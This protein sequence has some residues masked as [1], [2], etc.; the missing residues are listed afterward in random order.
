MTGSEIRTPVL[1]KI[2]FQGCNSG[3]D[4]VLVECREVGTHAAIDMTDDRQ[5]QCSI[6]GAVCVNAKQ[7]CGWCE[8][9]EVHYLCAGTYRC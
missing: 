1:K 5:V 2:C 3:G 4:P 7:T 6:D 9:Y 8:D